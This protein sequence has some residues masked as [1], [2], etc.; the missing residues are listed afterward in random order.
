V[1]LL[2]G[3]TVYISEH[4]TFES[5]LFVEELLVVAL[6]E[7]PPLLA[8]IALG[9]L[10]DFHFVLLNL[11]FDVKILACDFVVDAVDVY[12]VR[13]DSSAL[14]QLDAYFQPGRGR[15]PD[16]LNFRFSQLLGPLLTLVADLQKL[17][18][19]LH[20]NGDVK[21]PSLQNV[22]HHLEIVFV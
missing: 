2:S 10:I 9:P 5:P 17:S 14:H 20:T 15:Q 19:I 3:F 11:V 12:D 21:H 8:E 16:T 6:G 22:F 13:R 7:S 1:V 18:R 4:E